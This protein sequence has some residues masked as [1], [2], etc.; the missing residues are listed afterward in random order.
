MGTSL[1]APYVAG[2]AGLLFSQDPSR[3]ART[4][5]TYLMTGATRGGRTAGGQ[6]IANA[7]ESLRRGAE[8]QGAPLCGNRV[9]AEGAQIY[10]S[11][12]TGREAIGPADEALVGDVLS[13]HGGRAI[14]Y[15]STAGGGTGKALI[16]QTD[17]TW[18]LGAIPS[19]Y[20]QQIGGATWSE[21]QYAHF[22][23]DSIVQLIPSTVDVN[24]NYWWRSQSQMQMPIVLRYL[25]NGAEARKQL[26][27]LTIPNL[28]DPEKSFCVEKT[29]G[30][31]C[32]F[33]QIS[34][35]YWLYR[36]SYPQ[37]YQP[38]LISVTPLRLESVDSTA[39]VTC[40][41]DPSLLCRLA[42]TDYLWGTTHVYRIPLKGGTPQLVDSLKS[43]VFWMGQ[44]EAPGSDSLTM[45]KGDW[46]IQ[47]WYD[48]NTRSYTSANSVSKVEGCAMQ[49]RSLG[50]FPTVAQE[51]ANS[52][53][54]GWAS[55]VQPDNHGGATFSPS[56]A[57]APPGGTGGR[58]APA[59]GEYRIRI[60]DVMPRGAVL[61]R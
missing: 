34:G 26:G 18:Q 21:R 23:A 50:T 48:P 58:G 46:T 20:N 5:R 12:G 3:T 31:S 14:L 49:Y 52:T 22:P 47:Y 43:T 32:T 29:T 16:R 11:R 27:L 17:G 41:R 8:E 24:D 2:I 39:W 51:I 33:W 6:P 36:I 42:R 7:Y 37:A 4:V 28:P 19:D 44:S 56:R 15:N 40:T 13:Q 30:G 61:R 1:S 57:P 55:L 35:R 25:Q 60:E 53:Q 9:W 59:T 10:A 45:A 54:C 38:V